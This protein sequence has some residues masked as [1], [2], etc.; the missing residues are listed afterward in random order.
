MNCNGNLTEAIETACNY[1]ETLTDPSI[2]ILSI[3]LTLIGFTFYWYVI[4]PFQK[5]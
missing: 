3:V 2:W 4:E 1:T 5:S